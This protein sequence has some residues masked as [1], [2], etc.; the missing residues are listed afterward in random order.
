M[1]LTNVLQTVGV[2]VATICIVAE[3]RTEIPADR[4]IPMKALEIAG[5]GCSAPKKAIPEWLLAANWRWRAAIASVYADPLV[6]SRC[7]RS[8]LT[9]TR[10][11]SALTRWR[12]ADSW[13]ARHTQERGA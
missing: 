5:T 7:T 9:Y 8:V 10:G 4:E 3:F 6:R 13:L 11:V 1:S 12:E 2:V